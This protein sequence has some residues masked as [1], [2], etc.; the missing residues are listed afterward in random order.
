MSN[1]TTR[2]VL[3]ARWLDGDLTS[4]EAAQLLDCIRENDENWEV[5]RKNIWAD[6][7]LQERFDILRKCHY[8]QENSR[9]NEQAAHLNAV[10]N[11]GDDCTFVP[12]ADWE[13]LVQLER[14]AVPVA[15][16][17]RKESEHD[18]APLA[19][20]IQHDARLVTSRDK[21]ND[22]QRNNRF[23]PLPV[24]ILAFVLLIGSAEWFAL[25]QKQKQVLEPARSVGAAQVR[26]TI[27]VVWSDGSP[28]IKRGQSTGPDVF[29]FES[30]LL[31][32]DFA[33]GAELVVEGPARLT[34]NGPAG[35]FCEEGKISAHVLP[36]A[37]GFT[38]ISRF[39][40]IIDRGTE[41]YAEITKDEAKVEVIS[42]RVELEES[43][44]RTPLN[45][46][47]TNA[48]RLCHET[49]PENYT[50][51]RSNYIDTQLLQTRLLEYTQRQEKYKSTVNKKIDFDP[52]LLARF[53]FSQQK[54][55]SVENCS[56]ANRT[57]IP[58]ATLYGCESTEGPL[59]GTHATRFTG[60]ESQADFELPGQYNSMTLLARVRID[61]LSNVGNVI[62]STDSYYDNVPG[63]FLWQI[64][65]DGNLQFQIVPENRLE[66]TSF[67]S[68]PIRQQKE[69]GIWFT[70][71]VT[72]DGPHKTITFYVDGKKLSSQAWNTPIPLVPRQ[73]RI[74]N[75]NTGTHGMSRRFFEGALDEFLL[76]DRV[77]TPEEIAQWNR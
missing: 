29:S 53:D 41:F 43:S 61:R 30:G 19:A 51:E 32:L 57:R 34:I 24:A 40:A 23:W 52:S 48:V 4:D 2:D 27:D 68:D 47:Q 65:K 12:S 3:I 42:G 56:V 63:A 14:D 39:G 70:T 6:F 50:F 9:Q 38:V 58:K 20:S 37:I 13:Q 17:L 46:T 16:S 66:Q 25:Q 44:E 60:G 72:I 26:E 15:K 62:F 22:P 77:L 71:A 59:Y 54:T 45:L 5:L 10:S 67:I 64:L 18:S 36:R 73:C 1:N 74:G 49:K 35:C 7:F 28:K 21:K 8:E 31:K 33:D 55:D 11:S 69:G 76:F 75:M